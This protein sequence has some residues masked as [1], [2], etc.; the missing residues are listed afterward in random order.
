MVAKTKLFLTFLIMVFFLVPACTGCDGTDRKPVFQQ[1][2]ELKTIKQEKPVKIKLK[3][4]ASGNYSWEISGYDA[5][6]I[7]EENNKL[8]KSVEKDE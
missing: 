4:G 2:P 1:V 5:D 3:R 7:I 8:K 6:R